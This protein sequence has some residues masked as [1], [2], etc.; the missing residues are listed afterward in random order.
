MRPLGP[1]GALPGDFWGRTGMPIEPKGV[2]NAL[3]G[4]IQLSKRQAPIVRAGSG[5]SHEARLAVLEQ[6]FS[7]DIQARCSWCSQVASAKQ[8]EWLEIIISTPGTGIRP[9]HVFRCMGCEA[10]PETVSGGM[11]AVPSG[12]RRPGQSPPPVPEAK[13]LP[14]PDTGGARTP[15]ARRRAEKGDVLTQKKGKGEEK[16]VGPARGRASN[17]AP[18]R[19]PKAPQTPVFPGK[20]SPAP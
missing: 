7:D 5:D 10:A 1:P 18:R 8:G 6:R 16:N 13:P 12:A 9:A 17:R 20:L 4:S 2:I 3:G 15:P 19:A 11:V 14:I